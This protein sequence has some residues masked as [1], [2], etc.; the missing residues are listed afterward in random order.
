MAEQDKRVVTKIRFPL[1]TQIIWLVVALMIAVVIFV[2]QTT[3]RDE[4]AALMRQMELRGEALAL[5]L[6]N[7]TQS[8]LSPKVADVL[9]SMHL[10]KV[11]ANVYQQ[12]DFFE[13]N[14]SESVEKMLEQEDAIYAYILNPFQQIIGHSDKKYQSL[15]VWQM[16][17]GVSFYK[18]IY[19]NGDLVKPI[20]QRY[21]TEYKSPKTGEMVEHE[22]IDISFPLKEKD[23]KKSLKTYEGE[24]H[25]GL[26]QEGIL[27]TLQDA[28]GKLLN[29]AFLAVFVGIIGAYLL[30]LFI[31]TPIKKLVKAMQIVAKGDLGQSVRIKRRDEIG[32]LGASFNVMTEGLREKE[33]IRSTFNKFVSA[34]VAEEVLKTEGAMTLGGEYKEVTMFFSDIRNF[35]GMS[36]KIQPHQVI[37]FLNEY[38]S[39]M[40]DI[41][42]KYKG[43]IDKYVG[44]EIMALWGAPIKR[45]NDV[46][47]C[48]RSAIEQMKA[49]AELNKV[50]VARGE[51][52]IQI[53]MGINTGQVISGSMGSEK[54]LDYTVIGDNVNLASRLCSNA[55]KKGLH[56][57]IA[58]H[59]TYERV[60][61]IVIAHEVEP[62]YVKGK[63]LPIRIWEIMD[64]KEE[65]KTFQ[66]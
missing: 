51:I 58:S 9:S 8:V 39:I 50:R 19:K 60:Q 33:K 17:K 3:L 47:L 10:N 2:Y 20:K 29:V 64:I 32:L 16:P 22:I 42:I 54:R 40:T 15:S 61:D 24:V 6:A 59:A 56:N 41:I 27:S 25:I 57:I 49:L 14:I 63:E 1:S 35:T 30:A 43:V 4:K 65:F 28:K 53:G 7:N 11:N 13:L 45:D 31:S 38:L 62:I 21:I 12:I 23:E 5:N 36:E 48:I 46:E 18:D 44:D 37:S 55:G 52:E 26:S 66:I 34:E